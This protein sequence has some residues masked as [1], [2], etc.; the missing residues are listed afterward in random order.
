[1][2]VVIY[3]VKQSLKP[4]RRWIKCPTQML[5]VSWVCLYVIFVISVMRK[6]LDQ[7]SKQHAPHSGATFPQSTLSVT[8]FLV[9]SLVFFPVLTP[10]LLQILFSSLSADLLAHLSECKVPEWENRWKDTRARTP[11]HK[12]THVIICKHKSMHTGAQAHLTNQ[13]IDERRN[14]LHTH[15]STHFQSPPASCL[16]TLH[17]INPCVSLTKQERA[18]SSLWTLKQ[19][20]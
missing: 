9:F 11:A 6:Y 16:P 10:S 4:K 2:N 7:C 13:Y 15:T 14:L 1:M 17:L 12:W 5:S 18:L 20:A 3:S 8:L 19:V